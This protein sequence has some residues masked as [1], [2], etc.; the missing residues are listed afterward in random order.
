MGLCDGRLFGPGNPCELD[1]LLAIP[2]LTH[3]QP[4]VGKKTLGAEVQLTCFAFAIN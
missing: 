1:W 4:V 3:A 2:I